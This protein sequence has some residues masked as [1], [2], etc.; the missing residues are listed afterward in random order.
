MSNP[1][2]LRIAPAPSDGSTSGGAY[3]SEYPIGRRN[4]A[5]GWTC[6]WLGIVSGSILMAWSFAGPFPAPGGFEDYGM[7]SRRMSRLAHIAQIMLPIINILLGRDLD[8]L[9][10]TTRWKQICS[11]SAIIGLI[12]VPLGLYLGALVDIRLKYVSVLP[13][14]AFL[15][16][17]YLM[18][19]GTVRAW[20]GKS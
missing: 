6:M 19:L 10:L 20:R 8:R 1:T 5:W 3:L 17:L 2:P 9:P 11:W 15:L 7:L 18:A 13:V 16:A 4:I 14:N 12:G